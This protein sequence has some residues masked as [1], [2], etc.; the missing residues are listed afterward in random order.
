VDPVVLAA[1]TALVGAMATDAWR[2]VHGSIVGVW[3]HIHP[4]HADGI[5]TELEA[6]RTRILAARQSGDEDTE[7]ALAG[8]WRLRLQQLVDADPAAAD[9]VRRLLDEQLAPALPEDQQDTVRSIVMKAEARDHARVYM[10][11]RDIQISGQ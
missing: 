4:A 6:D 9:L 3:R 5:G 1:G 10:A 2:Q 11:G 7:Q 8:M